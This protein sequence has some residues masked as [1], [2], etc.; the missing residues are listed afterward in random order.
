MLKEFSLLNLV[1]DQLFIHY[2][3]TRARH[4]K[5]LS[6]RQYLQISSEFSNSNVLFTK[7]S[8]LM[9]NPN[10]LYSTT[11]ES[12]APSLNQKGLLISLKAM[13]SSF[14][15]LITR[16][17]FSRTSRWFESYVWSSS[18]SERSKSDDSISNKPFS[19]DPKIFKSNFKF[20][21]S[22]ESLRMDSI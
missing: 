8:T 16:Q 3:N 15:C 22:F 1:P 18:W 19:R 4:L 14:Y 6:T 21:N 12:K 11:K 17:T 20:L 10:P 13:Q 2:F 5:R 7:M 9:Q